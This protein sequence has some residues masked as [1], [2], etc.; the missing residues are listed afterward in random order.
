T[1]AFD[2]IKAIDILKKHFINTMSHELRTPLNSI[3]GFSELLKRKTVGELNEKQEHYIDNIQTGGNRL[4]NII[5]QILEVVRMENGTSELHIEKIPV[6]EIVDVAIGV[7]KENAEKNNV[8]VEKTLDSKL[9]YI[10]AD[11]QKLKQVFINLLENA[12]KFSKPEGGVVSV[13]AKRKG[14]MAEFS[15]SDT[16]IGIKEEDMG[17]LFQKFTQLESGT[18]RKY[19]GTGLGLAITKQ[20][21]EL[22]GGRIM[23][24]SKYGEGSTFTF[25]IPLET[26]KGGKNK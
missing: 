17:K 12:V 5:S 14:D 3:L 10:E 4:L 16:G 2:D 11:W 9:E 20:L 22:H 23:V 19:G 7:I 24:E 15:I 8:V 18:T 25:S 26:K 1:K 21:V 13:R 6:P